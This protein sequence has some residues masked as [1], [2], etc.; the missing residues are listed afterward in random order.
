[1]PRRMQPHASRAL[2]LAA[3]AAGSGLASADPAPLPEDFL[4][5]LAT[6]EADDGDWLVANAATVAVTPATRSTGQAAPA[7]APP[8]NRS[9]TAPRGTTAAP[10]PGTERK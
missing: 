1:M 5:Y 7:A 4:E 3:M 2:L 8:V 10:A 9:T 6:W